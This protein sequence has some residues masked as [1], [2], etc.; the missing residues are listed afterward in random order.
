MSHFLHVGISVETGTDAAGDHPHGC[1][2]PCDI[3]VVGERRL[4]LNLLGHK[5]RIDNDE[6]AQE[7]EDDQY[8]VESDHSDQQC[9]DGGE[10]VVHDHRGQTFVDRSIPEFVT[11]DQPGD[12]HQDSE[13]ADREQPEGGQVGRHLPDRTVEDAESS[14][15]RGCREGS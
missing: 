14:G 13:R 5:C 1:A 6:A 10:V 4:L 12:H 3:E 8:R 15:C 2:E 7:N 11:G 9:E